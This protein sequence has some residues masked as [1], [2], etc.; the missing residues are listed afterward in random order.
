MDS[1]G[2][3]PAYFLVIAR[4]DLELHATLGKVNNGFLH[5]GLRWV[6]EQQETDKNHSLL[7]GARIRISSI[8]QFPSRHAEYAEA[9]LAPFAVV[10]FNPHQNF[11]IQWKTF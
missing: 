3:M 9:F 11:A 10:L 2:N 4:D 8:I 7:I 1:L 5:I 6:E